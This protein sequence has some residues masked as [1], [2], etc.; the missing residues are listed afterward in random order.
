MFVSVCR[1]VVLHCCGRESE[2]IQARFPSKAWEFETFI[3]LCHSADCWVQ[4]HLS[5]NTE[6]RIH[7][8]LVKVSHC[9][10]VLLFSSSSLLMI[11]CS[12]QF[13]GSNY[14]KAMPC[15]F[16]SLSLHWSISSFIFV[17][18]FRSFSGCLYFLPLSNS[19][20][21]WVHLLTAATVFPWTDACKH[22]QCCSLLFFSLMSF[23]SM[24]EGSNISTVSA[25][26]CYMSLEHKESSLC[27][28]KAGSAAFFVLFS[29]FRGTL[30]W[31]FGVCGRCRY[32]ELTGSRLATDVSVRGCHCLE[33]WVACI[34]APLPL[35]SCRPSSSIP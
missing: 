15:W 16:L 25:S 20:P 10:I 26:F 21:V 5:F 8:S 27:L 7:H 28:D 2:S 30:S 6:K 11:I 13:A 22:R 12:L 14:V 32:L 31:L 4:T 1:W 34:N 23:H 19:V 17:Y 29:Y 18:L 9:S 24:K 33:P 3:L 35:L